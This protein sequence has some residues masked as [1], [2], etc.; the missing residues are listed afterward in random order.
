MFGQYAM[1]IVELWNKHEFHSSLKYFNWNVFVYILV[2]LQK[3]NPYRLELK[4]IQ[5]N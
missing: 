1:H 3:V 2:A 5:N 4:S